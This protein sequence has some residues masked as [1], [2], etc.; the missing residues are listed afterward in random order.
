MPTSTSNYELPTEDARFT[1][2]EEMIKHGFEL[3]DAQ[4]KK[5]ADA[6]EALDV[7]VV[8]LEEPA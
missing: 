1:S 5:S 8:A 6:V 4:M 7:R 3:I 2:L